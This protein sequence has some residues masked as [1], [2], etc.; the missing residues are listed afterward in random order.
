MTMETTYIV[1]GMT[2]DHCANAV[3]GEVSSIEG[4]SQVAVN[5]EGGTVT[6]TSDSALAL[7]DVAAA[8][9]EAGYELIS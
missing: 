7:G 2:C 9:E 1:K 3:S 6:V 5:V 4:V 8:V